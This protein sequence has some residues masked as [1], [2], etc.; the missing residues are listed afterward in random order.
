MGSDLAVGTGLISGI[1]TAGL[2][3][4][5]M[6]LEKQP[7][8]K[9]QQKKTD[10]ETKQ[11][12]WRDVNTRLYNLQS[13]M[14]TLQSSTTFMG[15]KANVSDDDYF[16][17]T[18]TTGAAI[19][20]YR[21]EVIGLAKAHSVS[22]KDIAS[23]STS[24]GYTGTFQINGKDVG[25]VS[26]DT[27][28]SIAD[29][30]NTT[31]DI[32]V[33]ASVVKKADNQYVMT[34]T[35]KKTGETNAIHAGD[36]NNPADATKTN[37]L[38]T[39]GIIGTDGSFSTTIQSAQNAEISVNGLAIERDSNTINDAIA[40]VTLNLKKD[41]G[42]STMDV[43]ADYDSIVKAAKDFVDQYN[44][45]MSFITE[46]LSYNKTTKTK[47]DLYGESSLLYL[48]SS[49]RSYI[50]KNVSDVPAA[51][52]TMAMVGISSGAFN[53]SLD[54]TKAGTLELD[55]TKFRKA[56]NEHYD[57]VAKLFGAT[58]VN[59]ASSVNGGTVTAT[60][61][62]GDQYPVT[63]LIDGRTGSDDWGNGGGW[64]GTTKVSKDTPEVLEF[65][66][67]GVKTVDS[68]NLFNLSS[69]TYPAT[70]NSIKDVSFEYLTKDDQGNDVWKPLKS[71]DD[72]TKNLEITG[73][74]NAIIA[75]DF[76]AVNTSKIRVKI[77]GTN[78]SDGYA[79][80][81]EVQIMQKNTGVFANMYDQVY[82]VTRSG[83]SISRTLD[84]LSDEAKDN[85]DRITDLTTKLE[86][87]QAYYQAKFTAMETALSK[88]QD[89]QSSLTN[90][91]T[92]LSSK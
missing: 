51:V 77:T 18:A 64:M 6:A 26:T 43:T 13:K 57:D 16:T 56:L 5:L 19:T 10:L 47:G 69:T 25:V 52:N 88:L 55:E 44:S 50:S 7:L 67:S 80:L 35:S 85:D 60:S 62:N 22:S 33:T 63:S 54:A 45:T 11:T 30:I 29:K 87:K 46:K 41:G 38:Q 31:A 24:L 72:P 83:G 12:A 66:F 92:Q 37:I 21:V 61:Q 73:N 79:K 42:G 8:T 34:L 9:A 28:S 65:S 1:D 32:G 2:I 78:S 4:K 59:S 17:A 58:V 27:L 82:N 86:T 89:Q 81:S 14:K 76:V 75:T 39:L 53:Q 23:I 74:S 90:Y 3:D 70:S 68:I 84:N 71:I 15:R 91:L 20:S 36:T 40:G 49:L 48:Q